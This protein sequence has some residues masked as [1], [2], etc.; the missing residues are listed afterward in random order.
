MSSVSL[1][2]DDRYLEHDPGEDHP[3]SADRLRVIHALVASEF[4]DLP[5]I[6]P[7][8]AT[9][10]ELAL[11]HDPNYIMTVAA[12][13][14]KP[15]SRLDMD[16]GL[17][18]RSYEIARLAAGGLLNAVDSL[19]TPN[20]EPRTLHSIFA[21]VRPP[22][23]H[24][25][26]A[27]GMGFCLFNNVA[28]AAAYAKEKWGLKKVLIVDWDLHH[29]NGTQR[30][31]Y[32]DPSVLF[33]SSHQYP[34]YPGT[35]SFDEVG[36]GEGAGFTVNA[37]LP[38]GFGDADYIALYE[39]VLRPIA[40]EYQPELI[41]VSAG[42]DPFIKDPLGG[43][44]VT[45]AGFGALAAIVLDLARQCCSGRVVMTLEGGYNPEGLRDGTR[46]V[47]TAMRDQAV[48]SS[49][50]PVSPAA[51]RIIEQIRSRHGKYWKSLG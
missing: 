7:R 32:S 46:A 22:G 3:E 15:F 24:A 30:A 10:D 37:P 16:T 6:E 29:G 51:D 8:L 4:A 5:R 28:V 17:S 50:R 41:L 11:V 40:L 48:P 2:L 33:F 1:I 44:R 23:H 43:M 31:F 25:E 39:G 36:S 38:S 47:L 18:A 49:G 27:R 45:G 19:L 42:F 13:A 9:E 26:P 21:F 35:G 14:G 20:S 12:T 34:H